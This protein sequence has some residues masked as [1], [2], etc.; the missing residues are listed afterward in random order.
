M[1]SEKKGADLHEIVYP[2]KDRL[3]P[4][5]T[6]VYNREDETHTLYPIQGHIPFFHSLP[7]S[8]LRADVSCFLCCTRKQE[9]SARRQPPQALLG[10]IVFL[11]SGWGGGYGGGYFFLLL[12]LRLRGR[13]LF[14]LKHSLCLVRSWCNNWLSVALALPWVRLTT[15]RTVTWISSISVSFWK[16]K[17]LF[18]KSNATNFGNQKCHLRNQTRQ[19]LEIKMTLKPKGFFRLIIDKISK[20]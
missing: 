4:N 14:S 8:C 5:Y 16:S 19:I 13:L 15:H 20:S 10:E 6:P 7:R 2:V 12:L 18:E 9:T 1:P 17:L 11:P 3:A